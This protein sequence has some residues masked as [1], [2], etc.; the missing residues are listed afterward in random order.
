MDVKTND[1]VGRLAASFGRTVDYLRE[2]ATP[3]RPSP[4]AT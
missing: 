3:P 1:E 4:T 2:K